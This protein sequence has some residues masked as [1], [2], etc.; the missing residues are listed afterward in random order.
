MKVES[1]G[2]V[3]AG[4]M[5]NGIV[6]IAA[7]AGLKIVL[8]DITETALAKGMTTKPGESFT[9]IGTL[10]KCFVSSRTVDAVSGLA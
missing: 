7:V 5:G 6:Q 1:V 9:V 8:M 4:A 10:P 2:V 3:G